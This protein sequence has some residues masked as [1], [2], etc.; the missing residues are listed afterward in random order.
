VPG[1]RP[2]IVER[3]SLGARRA[4]CAWT[5]LAVPLVF[6][7]GIRFY[8][9]ADAF[10]MSLTDWNIVGERRFVGLAN[11]RRL[12]ADPAF[13]IVMGNTF[14]YLVVGVAASLGLAFL[15]AYHLDRVRF[16]HALL[17]ALYFVPHVT[18]AVAMAWVWRWLYQPV[19]VGLVNGL[20]V[21][22]GLPQ[23]PFLRSTEQALYAVLAPAIWAGLGFQVVIFLAGL[24][25]IPSEYYEAAAIDGAGGWRLLVGVTLP[26]LRPTIVFLVV[27]SSIAFLRIFDYVYGMTN[28]QGGPLD[29]TKPLALKIYQTA[30]GHFE[31]GYAAAHTVLLFFILLAI[32]LLQ[33]RLLRAR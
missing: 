13:W 12:A 17:R 20:L 7:V 22:L 27:V 21:S 6:Y 26:L 8:P 18:T 23:Q 11:Y 10:L 24:R 25:A 30:F 32:S 4:L 5:F 33:I 1:R 19:P 2:A 3:L 31:M 14:Q 28:G 15:V 9:A 16:G 29:A